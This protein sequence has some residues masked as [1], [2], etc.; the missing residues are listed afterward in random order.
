MVPGYSAN[1]KRLPE[2]HENAV[3][4]IAFMKYP[5]SKKSSVDITQLKT[6]RLVV[7]SKELSVN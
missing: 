4:V 6:A 7:K 3:K 5:G 2:N 1:T